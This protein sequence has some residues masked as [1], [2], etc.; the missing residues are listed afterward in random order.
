MAVAMAVALEEPCIPACACLHPWADCGAALLRH[1]TDAPRL[2]GVFVCFFEPALTQE[3][4][5]A[6]MVWCRPPPA[7]TK[8]L[9]C[10]SSKQ[11]HESVTRPRPQQHPKPKAT[12]THAGGARTPRKTT[13]RVHRAAPAAP[14]ARGTGAAGTAGCAASAASGGTNITRNA[15]R[16]T[17]SY[18]KGTWASAPARSATHHSRGR[19]HNTPSRKVPMHPR[20]LLRPRLWAAKDI[21]AVKMARP[22]R[23]PRLA[24][25][26]AIRRQALAAPWRSVTW[27]GR[28]GAKRKK[29][30][31]RTARNHPGPTTT[32]SGLPWWL[33]SRMGGQGPARSRYRG[34]VRELLRAGLPSTLVR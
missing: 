3:H 11:H 18:T 33:W 24:L 31:R 9:R 23:P 19:R 20:Q 32:R 34:L 8:A 10:M 28:S 26:L 13:G 27:C 5:R 30:R 1:S 17:L 7:A 22:V 25:R 2:E 12:T 16:A 14:R 6:N 15:G 29:T 4:C 21:G